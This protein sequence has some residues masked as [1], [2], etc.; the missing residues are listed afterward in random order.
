MNKMNKM[1]NNEEIRGHIRKNYA[2]IALKGAKGGG[3]GCAPGCCNDNET[4]I[5]G[6]SINIGYSEEDLLNIPV[7]ANMSLGCGNPIAIAALS[8]L[9]TVLDLGSGGGFDC[10][11]ARRKVGE[12]GYVIGVDMPPEMI[13][14]SRSNLQK[15]GYTNME[16][17]L[18]EIENLPV[19]DATIDVI[20]S[21]CVI[22]L[23]LDKQRVFKEAFRVL[24]TGG[25]LSISDVV[26]TAEL[27]EQVK[28][29][30]SM[31]AGCIAGA[32]YIGNIR[33]MLQNVG[34]INIKM[35]PKD[36]SKEIL[37]SWVPGKNVEDFVASYIIE[38][39]KK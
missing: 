4:D 35:I 11:F 32:E 16:F 10:F 7:D 14:L 8:E 38:A 9:E 22:N 24:K 28:N 1:N 5:K 19:A 15:S 3:C 17:R 21:N 39:K 2:N 33:A 34:F 12:T 23:S 20:I 27:P 29:D 30:L 31:M 36:N 6:N 13:K 37:S 26:A 18:G 25:R